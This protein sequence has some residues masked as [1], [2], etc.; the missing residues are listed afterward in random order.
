MRQRVR[1]FLSS[2]AR[3]EEQE[4]QD[5]ESRS[6]A[7]MRVRVRAGVATSDHCNSKCVE[8]RDSASK[9]ATRVVT[10]LRLHPEATAF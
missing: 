10:S 4:T 5:E 3:A 1:S 8:G 7:R 9:G 2:Q 6:T